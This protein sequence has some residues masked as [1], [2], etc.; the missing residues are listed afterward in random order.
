M[1]PDRDWNM[2]HEELLARTRTKEISDISL[3]AL[4]A[5]IFPVLRK[6]GSS[7]LVGIKTAKVK[8]RTEAF[9]WAKAP[10]FDP[11]KL[12]EIGQIETYHTCAYPGF[13]KPTEAECLA[14][15]PASYLDRIVLV[16][17]GGWD[18]DTIAIVA[19]GRGQRVITHL[20]ARSIK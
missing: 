11:G 14:Q 8:P 7:K 19:G 15:I 2:T 4:R 10:H 1:A 6:E 12:R 17:Y 5:R 18:M 16:A 3:N 13:F 20:Y 9:G